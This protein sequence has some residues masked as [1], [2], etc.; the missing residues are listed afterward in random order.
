MNNETI[1]IS[2]EVA[3]ADIYNVFV[4]ADYKKRSDGEIIDSIKLIVP[5]IFKKH[6]IPQPKKHIAERQNPVDFELKGG[7]TLSVKTSKIKNGKVAPQIIGQPTSETY[8]D[9][10]QS[11]IDREIP[12]DYELRRELFK[13]FTI[14]N[15]DI[16]MKHY[17][18][19][20]F[21]CDYLIYLYDFNGN[22]INYKVWTKIAPPNFIKTNFTF[23]RSMKFWKES[24]TVKYNN[25]SIGEFQVH[26]NRD[27]FKFRFNINGIVKAFNL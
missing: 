6:N 5:G 7:K 24:T 14:S 11:L 27:C 4:N 10:F 16:V 25:I 26:K 18:E 15:I 2:A 1:G 13:S 12:V 17:W 19:N 8:F 22:Q 9:Y 3:I 21:H 20:L 23:T